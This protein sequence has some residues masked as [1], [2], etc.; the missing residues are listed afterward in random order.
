MSL[1]DRIRA[2]FPFPTTRTSTVKGESTRNGRNHLACPGRHNSSVVDSDNNHQHFA[3]SC[4][5][6]ECDVG[7][8]GAQQSTITTTTK[9]FHDGGDNHS[10]DQCRLER[11]SSTTAATDSLSQPAQ[12]QSD[13][14][15]IDESQLSNYWPQKQPFNIYRDIFVLSQV[16]ANG[17]TNHE[18][19]EQLLRQQ[20]HKARI[21]TFF[22]NIQRSYSEEESNTDDPACEDFLPS[23]QNELQTQKSLIYQTNYSNF[24]N[25]PYQDNSLIE[26]DP[27]MAS[28]AP[29]PPPMPGTMGALSLPNWRAHPYPVRESAPTQNQIEKQQYAHLPDKLMNSM[30]KDKKP[31][32]YTPQGIGFV[33]T[34]FKTKLLFLDLFIHRREK[35]VLDMSEIRSP[36]MKKRLMAN[37]QAGEGEGND[38]VDSA[39]QTVTPTRP[40]PANIFQQPALPMVLPPLN[41]ELQN[42]IANRSSSPSMNSQWN[43][44]KKKEV[45][46]APSPLL[47]SDD[48][49]LTSLLEKRRQDVE[50]R[51]KIVTNDPVP[52][53]SPPPLQ[54][55]QFLQNPAPTSTYGMNSYNSVHA[56]APPTFTTPPTH[57]QENGFY[58]YAGSA[59]PP[60]PQHN[61]AQV[62][63]NPSTNDTQHF[64]Q[65][66]VKNA[67]DT[68]YNARRLLSPTPPPTLSCSV[69]T[70]S[71]NNQIPSSE[72]GGEEQ[73]EA[74]DNVEPARDERSVSDMMNRL[75]SDIHRMNIRD[76]NDDST[77]S[78]QFYR[79]TEQSDS[80]INHNYSQNRDFS[81]AQQTDQNQLNENYFDSS[82]TNTE[83]A[84]PNCRPPSG[85]FPY[86]APPQQANNNQQTDILKHVL[87][88]IQGKSNGCA[89]ERFF[90]L[91]FFA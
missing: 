40:P 7:G 73:V 52:E 25:D 86:S 58:S 26:Y 35:G 63:Y 4:T 79:N 65:N 28:T 8:I 24:E 64:D 51:S 17:V 16:A 45:R 47:V 15:R 50:S 37:L 70:D 13:C 27:V 85:H 71:N 43:E 77:Q 48:E 10:S 53:A 23:D 56:P 31:F 82:Q 57:H 44:Q 29:P 87:D 30:A 74:N 3:A 61:N 2:Y 1:F 84:T 76:G 21:Q 12:N 20:A 18:E 14:V 60:P 41:Q 91:L 9:F 22:E 38:D 89:D 33:L 42:K 62:G 88:G 55:Q 90:I 66:L 6:H 5:C 72:F 54:Q 69:V 34:I 39:A 11:D 80:Q 78:N 19:Y 36:K 68:V 83:M 67:T 59:P 81:D 49:E 32:T 75:E 46:F